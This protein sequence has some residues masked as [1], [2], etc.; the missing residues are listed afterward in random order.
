MYQEPGLAWL[1]CQ[2]EAAEQLLSPG[3]AVRE[4]AGVQHPGRQPDGPP[5]DAQ[6]D[7][8]LAEADIASK[9]TQHGRSLPST[10]GPSPAS[11]SA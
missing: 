11:R 8:D 1:E 3:G 2:A 9:V 4:A 5:A 7:V 10:T 6:V